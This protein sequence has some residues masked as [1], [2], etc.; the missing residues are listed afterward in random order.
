MTAAPSIHQR[1]LPVLE[2]ALGNT[3]WLEL[4][5]RP[6]WPAAVFSVE[7]APEPGWCAGGGY[8]AHDATV[9]VL[10]RSAVE[11]DTLLPTSGGGSVRAAV[12]AMEHYQ[13]EVGCEDAD[14]E[15]DPQV[16]ARA[17][18]VRLRTPRFTTAK[19]TP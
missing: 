8:D 7:T 1:L 5:A 11:L 13:W 17:L 6:T 3:W 19:D 16:Y 9:I 14:Y 12:E 4:P 2:S 10:S 15:D 18:I